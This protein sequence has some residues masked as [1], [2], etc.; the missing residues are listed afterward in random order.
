MQGRKLD[1]RPLTGG[2]GVDTL[3]DDFFLSYNA[4]RLRDACQ[5]FA[6]KMLE[7]DVTVGLTISGALTPDGSGVR[8]V[9]SPRGSRIRGLDRLHGRQPLP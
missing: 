9:R 5:I 1:P 3:V 2:I 6:D 4:G 8:G 7:A